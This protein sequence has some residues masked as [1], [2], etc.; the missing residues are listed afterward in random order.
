MT[1]SASDIKFRKSVIQT[2]TDVNG[3][4]KGMV[5]VVSGAR[6]A[7]FPRVTKMQREAG[8][9]RYRKQFYCNE[10]ADDEAAYGVLLYLMR[11]SNA[12]DRFYMAKGTQRDAQAQFARKTDVDTYAATRYA[13]TW[14]GCGQL[15]VAL[16]G[17]EVEVQLAMESDDYQFPNNGYL[18]LSDNT[19]TGQ[20]TDAEVKVG[21]SVYFSSGSWSRVAHTN[22]INY[23][24][25]WCAGDGDVLTIQ[26]TTNEEFLRIAKN[27]YVDEAIGAGDGASVTPALSRLTNNTSGICRQTGLL[28]VVSATCGGV[29]R[30]VNVAAN[31]LCSGYCAAG[32]LN[33][34]TGIWTTP[35]TWTAAPDN[36]TNITI[37][38]CEKAFAYSGNVATVE[39]ADQVANAYSTGVTFGA[40]CIHEDEVVCSFD[41]WTKNTA[42]G[43]YDETT[44]PPLLFNDGTAEDDWTLTF[45]SGSNFAAAGA[46]YGS[47]G[48]GSVSVDFSPINPDTGQPYFTI[49]SSGWG[50]TWQ[51]GETL[52]FTTHPSVI[53]ILLEEEVPA[54]TEQEPNNMVPIG[55][56]TE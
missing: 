51:N 47:I 8:L 26:S 41:G 40:G 32:Q 5:E 33:M 9:I 35:I 14:V 4:R 24:Y 48:T 22:N 53:P 27:E 43:T 36:L 37:T 13:R 39:L 11:P 2:D 10:N 21:D 50:G 54:A 6:H 52:A 28:P 12:G 16:T 38:Y 23:P 18:Y 30:T 15:E 46:Y 56:Y 29:L 44:Y 42:A 55:S 19:M 49:R 34:V 45:T 1:V 17:G 20:A 3:G 31:G 7:L 25:G